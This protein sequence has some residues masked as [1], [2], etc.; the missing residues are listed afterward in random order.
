VRQVRIAAN[1]A[2]RAAIVT[3]VAVA[4]APRHRSRARQSGL[5]ARERQRLAPGR[6]R[7]VEGLDAHHGRW[8]GVDNRGS[9]SPSDGF[10]D[11]PLASQAHPDADSSPPLS[12][13]HR[14]RRRSSQPS[15]PRISGRASAVVGSM[16][17]KY[18]P[19]RKG[20]PV[21][22]LSH[23]Y[24]DPLFRRSD[25]SRCSRG[26]GVRAAEREWEIAAEE[27]TRRCR[28]QRQSPSVVQRVALLFRQRRGSASLPGR[29]LDRPGV[30]AHAAARA[31]SRCNVVLTVTGPPSLMKGLSWPEPAP[32]DC[33]GRPPL[34]RPA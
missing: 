25:R 12:R 13:F 16:E 31:P 11:E 5:A 3:G 14:V 28:R 20:A 15:A 17:P 7:K 32:P 6:M 19:V 2:S 8:R 1:R 34:R 10:G 33:R 23:R 26:T 18:I 9:W 22:A 30:A 27:E 4:L 21:P 29:V 24:P